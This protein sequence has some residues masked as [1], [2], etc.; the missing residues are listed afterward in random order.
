MRAAARLCLLA[1]AA[2]ACIAASAF[3]VSL[4]PAFRECVHKQIQPN[5]SQPDQKERARDQILAD[6]VA[7]GYCAVGFTDQH[8]GTLAALFAAALV[9][10]GFRQVG[11]NRRQAM[12]MDQQRELTREQIDLAQRAAKAF[13][14]MKEIMVLGLVGR[15]IVGPVWENGGSEATE[16]LVIGTGW[17]AINGELADDF[18]YPITEETPAFLGPHATAQISHQFIDQHKLQAA[19]DGSQ[20]V[21][22]WGTAHYADT[23]E[24]NAT[25][26]AEFC[27]EIVRRGSGGLNAVW[28]FVQSG[29]H[30]RAYQV[31]SHPPASNKAT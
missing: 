26:V 2:A 29:P 10:V 12:I 22:V 15:S 28:A 30:N 27:V 1:A 11:V 14:Y 5:A 23:F 31:K 25:N 19:L 9:I 8:Q 16:G 20:R 6:S 17:T 13:V 21:F 18:G 24:A 4:S 7:A 3:V